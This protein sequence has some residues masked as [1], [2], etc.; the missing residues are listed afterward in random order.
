MSTGSMPENAGTFQADWK[1]TRAENPSFKCYKCGSD[2]VWY[3]TWDSLCGGYTDV[4]YECQG[5][6]HRWWVESSDA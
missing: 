4:K 3:R 6:D 2:D 1:P 5:C